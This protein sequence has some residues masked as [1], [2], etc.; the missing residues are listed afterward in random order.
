MSRHVST[1][2]MEIVSYKINIAVLWQGKYL[3][4]EPSDSRFASNGIIRRFMVPNV[5]KFLYI[6]PEDAKCM[7]PGRY[8]IF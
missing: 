5:L 1:I 3:C 4:A 7:Y 6:L 8:L 2:Q